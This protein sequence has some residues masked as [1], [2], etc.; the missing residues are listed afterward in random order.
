MTLKAGLHTVRV[1]NRFLGDKIFSISL[2]EGQTGVVTLE[3]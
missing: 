1:E 3:W 2:Q